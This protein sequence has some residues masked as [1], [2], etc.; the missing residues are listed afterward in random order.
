MLSD[1]H[2]VGRQFVILRPATV[3][4]FV[5]GATHRPQTLCG[6]LHPPYDDAIAAA[7]G[8]SPHSR[9]RSRRSGRAGHGDMA[10]TSQGAPRKP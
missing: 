8:I 10:R 2:T 7:R 1:R 4:P 9:C 3:E 5:V 6:G